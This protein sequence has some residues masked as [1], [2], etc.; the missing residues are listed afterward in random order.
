M[1]TQPT[2][3]T[4]TTTTHGAAPRRRCL[5]SPPHRRR[6]RHHPRHNSS[7][8][9]TQ[10]RLIPADKFEKEYA[11]NIRHNYGKEGKRA[12]Y[13]AHSCVKV[14]AA[15]PHRGEHHGCPFKTFDEPA[16]RGLLQR[17]RCVSEERGRGGGR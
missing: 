11:Y 3:L 12:D 7:T 8:N 17:M 9:T 2:P 5:R 4:T 13:T 15:T 14:I 1:P 6:H 10:P 16:L